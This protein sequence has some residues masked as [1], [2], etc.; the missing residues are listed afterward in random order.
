MVYMRMIPQDLEKWN[1]TDWTWP[2]VLEHYKNLESYLG[3]T[4]VTGEQQSA[5]VDYHGFGGPM[6][7]T[8]PGDIDPLATAFVASAMEAGVPYT[9]DFNHPAQRLGVG[10][11]SFNIRNGI[12]DSAARAFLSAMLTDPSSYPNFKLSLNSRVT[13]ILFSPSPDKEGENDLGPDYNAALPQAIGVEYER[14]G[15][16]HTARL[17]TAGG[18]EVV[19]SAGAL[20]SPQLLMH[21]GI[22][23]AKRLKAL[24][25]EP[26]VRAEGVGRNLQDHPVVAITFRASP[27]LM[28]G[29]L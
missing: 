21:S 11:Y 7:T 20:L 6:A 1:L 29:M 10:Y 27:S 22:G 19:L 2:T 24:G 14:N 15:Y 9:A 18:G 28:Q 12:R 5:A 8:P 16:V 3:E 25:L 23:P 4:D 13:R 17:N 26:V